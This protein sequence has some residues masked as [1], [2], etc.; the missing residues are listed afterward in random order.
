[1]A[2]NLKMLFS[3]SAFSSFDGIIGPV[4]ERAI[5]IAIASEERKHGAR[6]K[7]EEEAAE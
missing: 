4:Q 5:A 7:E 2:C 6:H 1:M 3:L